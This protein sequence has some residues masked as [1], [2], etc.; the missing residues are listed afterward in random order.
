MQAATSTEGAEVRRLRAQKEAL[1]GLC[2]TL[3]ARQRGGSETGADDGTGAAA[4]GTSSAGADEASGG[5]GG[6]AAGPGPAGCVEAALQEM[7]L[8]GAGDGAGEAS[9]VQVQGNAA[10]AVSA[11][12]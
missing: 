11:P 1:E 8:P 4:A 10:A 5:C 6:R 3:Q 12:V 9:G 7:P 2:R